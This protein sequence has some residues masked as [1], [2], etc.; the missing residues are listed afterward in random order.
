MRDRLPP[1]VDFC[2]APIINNGRQRY[3]GQTADR[4][5]RR[6]PSGTGR[7]LHA[8]FV[9]SHSLIYIIFRS[10]PYEVCRKSVREVANGEEL[11]AHA[12]FIETPISVRL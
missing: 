1:F 5:P 10:K 9:T 12:V 8:S 3:K 11:P 6:L 2:S 4:F 7:L